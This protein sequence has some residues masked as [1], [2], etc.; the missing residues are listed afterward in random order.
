MPIS[1]YTGQ[2]GEFLIGVYFVSRAIAW[3]MSA[4]QYLS[5]IIIV[6]PSFLTFDLS[7]DFGSFFLLE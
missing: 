1:H 6:P 2:A 5:K 7:A 4:K 3:V